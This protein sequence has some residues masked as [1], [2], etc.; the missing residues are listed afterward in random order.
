[1][2]FFSYTAAIAAS[3]NVSASAVTIFNTTVS[4]RRLL[5]GATVNTQVTFPPSYY[6]TAADN[7]VKLLQSNPS[8]VLSALS[9]PIQRSVMCIRLSLH[10]SHGSRLS[11]SA[12]MLC[13]VLI[14]SSQ[15]APA[16]GLVIGMPCCNAGPTASTPNQD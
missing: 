1:M 11:E 5:A 10:R 6:S 14:D 13:Q 12:C 7:Y 2:C 16:Y 8:Q 15:G 9:G 4:R 3:A